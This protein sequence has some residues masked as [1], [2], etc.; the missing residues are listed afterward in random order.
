MEFKSGI[1]VVVHLNG[2]LDGSQYQKENNIKHKEP[3][4][5]IIGLAQCKAL[6]FYLII[7]IPV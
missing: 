6:F 7:N 5:C 4:Q 1:G 3:H 2:S